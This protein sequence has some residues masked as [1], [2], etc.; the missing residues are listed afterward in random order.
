MFLSGTRTRL[1]GGVGSSVGIAVELS[2]TSLRWTGLGSHLN[3]P[4]EVERN[5]IFTSSDR[6]R[7]KSLPEV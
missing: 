1:R 6:R 2:R 7:Y 3:P 5:A 4:I